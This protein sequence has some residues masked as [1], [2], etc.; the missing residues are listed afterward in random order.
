MVSGPGMTSLSGSRKRPLFFPRVF[1]LYH[2]CFPACHELPITSD[3]QVKNECLLGGIQWAEHLNDLSFLPVLR[4][5]GSKLSGNLALPRV[6][7]YTCE[8]QFRCHNCT[9]KKLLLPKGLCRA[10]HGVTK[11]QDA[12][13]DTETGYIG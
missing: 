6:H 5:W 12:P 9:R 2:S 10:A 11:A 1:M 8:V 3:I 13:K 4:F 7:L